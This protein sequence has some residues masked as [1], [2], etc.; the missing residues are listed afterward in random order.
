MDILL[1]QIISTC[2]HGD[3]RKAA[4]EGS[5]RPVE[6]LQPTRA[7][8]LPVDPFIFSPE[9]IH[10]SVCLPRSEERRRRGADVGGVRRSASAKLPPAPGR[11]EHGAARP[12]IFAAQHS[13]VRARTSFSRGLASEKTTERAAIPRF[14]KRR[15]LGVGFKFFYRS[16]YR[17]KYNYKYCTVL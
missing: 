17:E 13:L 14:L 4:G 1:G 9:I 16:T 10:L 3:K 2:F 6:T 12:R 7:N 15:A 8:Y 5:Q 11:G